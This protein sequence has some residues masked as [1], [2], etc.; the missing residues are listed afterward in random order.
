MKL[1]LIRHG[2]TKWLREGRYQGTSDIALNRTGFLQA[3][4]VGK[5]L[6]NEK[7]SLI[8]SSEL[9]RANQTAHA[10][11]KVCGKKIIVDKRLNE[12]CF[13]NWEGHKH[14]KILKKFPKDAQNWYAAN[15]QSCPPGGES[16][17]S[18]NRRVSSFLKDLEAYYSKK[19]THILVSHGGVI[20]MFFI[21]LL[22]IS[23]TIF[24]TIRIDPCSISVIHLTW[25]RKELVLLN[26]QTHLIP[27][28]VFPAAGGLSKKDGLSGQK[29]GGGIN[30]YRRN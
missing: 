26:S 16:L 7:P 21:R 17:K 20:R 3:R 5:A 12:I 18:L 9:I 10:I 8:Y 27:P 4:A 11:A 15:W 13:G 6:K 19:E 29:A 28:P 2:E 25:S 24:W 30:G 22:R 23:P 1:I 14:V